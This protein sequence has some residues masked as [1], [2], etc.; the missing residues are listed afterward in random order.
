MS[1]ENKWILNFNP[2]DLLPCL[3]SNEVK[4]NAQ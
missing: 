4:S 1:L 3:K 2:T